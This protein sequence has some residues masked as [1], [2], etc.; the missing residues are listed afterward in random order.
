V[1]EPRQPQGID[2]AP[3]PGASAAKDEPVVASAPVVQPTPVPAPVVKPAPVPAAKPAP[4]PQPRLEQ[5]EKGL[6]QSWAVQVASLSSQA[7]AD[8]LKGELTAKGHKAYTRRAGKAVRVYVGPKLSREQA[9]AD[10][11][12]I[13]QA[14]R[15]N[16]MVVRFTPE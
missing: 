14:F 12:A 3:M 7:A 6:S 2:P 13:D 5:N 10:K 9:D 11:R 16:S 1:A 4:A 8:R 15:V